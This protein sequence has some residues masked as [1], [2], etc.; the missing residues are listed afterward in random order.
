MLEI[1]L[2]AD[3]LRIESLDTRH[4]LSNNDANILGADNLRVN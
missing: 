4:Y 1:F 3:V 2:G